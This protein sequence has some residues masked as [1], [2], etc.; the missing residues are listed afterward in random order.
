MCK[1][2]TYSF[3]VYEIHEGREVFNLTMIM[4]GEE[5]DQV[6]KRN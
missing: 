6:N 1:I 5:M 4:I 3:A 2:T